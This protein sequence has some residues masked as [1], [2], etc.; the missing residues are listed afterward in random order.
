MAST[1]AY[2]VKLI[3]VGTGSTDLA[4]LAGREYTSRYTSLP[5]ANLP[6]AMRRDLDKVFTALT[7]EELPL[8][9]N[10]FLIRSENRSYDR[11]FGP[12][13]KAGSDDVEGT[14]GGR[15]YIQWGNRYIPISLGKEGVTVDINGQPVSLESE[16]SMFNFSGRGEDVALMIAVDEEDES[17]Q[18]VLP[19]AVR[20]T[21]YENVPDIKALNSLMKKNKEADIISLIENVSARGSGGSRQQAD[22]EFDFRDLEEGASYEV[23]SYRPCETR[24]GMSYRIILAN[25]P[26][27]GQTAETWAHTTLR[28]LL[29]TRPEITAEKPATLHIRERTVTDDN[30]VRMRCSLIL[31]HQEEVSDEDLNLDF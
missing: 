6:K 25:Y 29:A 8:E 3:E 23:I 24:F 10:T 12:V 1:T 15:S 27:E 31:T 26:S 9:E 22:V 21:D 5:N 7:G 11:L 13:L 14:E 4:P 20:F 16:F 28:P 17:G 30:K 19:V 2:T 18:V